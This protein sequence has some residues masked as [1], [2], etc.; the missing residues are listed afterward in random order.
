MKRRAKHSAKLRKYWRKWYWKNV[1]KNRAA[2]RLRARAYREANPEKYRDQ[3]RRAS[4]LPPADY[5]ETAACECCGGP[6][7]ENRKAFCLDHDYSTGKFRGWL[8]GA[9]NKGI[10]LLGDNLKGVMRAARYLRR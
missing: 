1:V 7:G 5:P 3:C 6:H 9:C 10:G 2:S 4:G 8:C